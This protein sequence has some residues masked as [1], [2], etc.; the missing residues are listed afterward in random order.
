[1]ALADV[2]HMNDGIGID[3]QAAHTIQQQLNALAG[4][5]LTSE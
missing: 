2:D 5:L 1:M 3:V 4:H